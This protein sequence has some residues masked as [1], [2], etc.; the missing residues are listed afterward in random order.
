MISHILSALPVFIF[1][2]SACWGN[3]L[4][5]MPQLSLGRTWC[6]GQV[7]G[8]RTRRD[9][10]GWRGQLGCR[11]GR[12]ETCGSQQA[13]CPHKR[14]HKNYCPQPCY[15]AKTQPTRG[16]ALHGAQ[17]LHD[18]IWCFLSFFMWFF[19][20]PQFFIFYGSV[21][22][23]LFSCTTETLPSGPFL[24]MRLISP[25]RPLLLSIIVVWGRKKREGKRCR[26]KRNIVQSFLRKALLAVLH[27][28]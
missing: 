27:S 22:L 15:V 10:R 23:L 2:L 19:F 24:T 1:L 14:T 16:A 3:R 18:R 6:A 21:T 7:R 8:N 13:T 20:S 9:P 4:L 28:N 25:Q 12:V 17:Q 11:A 5:R 26:G